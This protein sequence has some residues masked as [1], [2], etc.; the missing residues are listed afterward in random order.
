MFGK[1]GVGGCRTASKEAERLNGVLAGC[2]FDSDAVVAVIKDEA[3][4][5]AAQAPIGVKAEEID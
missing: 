5:D 1:Q 4:N 3:E 2:A